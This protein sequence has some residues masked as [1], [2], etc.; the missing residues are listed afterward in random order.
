M[1]SK[2]AQQKLQRVLNEAQLRAG[3]HVDDVDCSS[4]ISG[5]TAF[6]GRVLLQNWGFLFFV[7]SLH[8]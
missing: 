1:A 5:Q 8:W 3:L 2:Q 6:V 4:D 7:L